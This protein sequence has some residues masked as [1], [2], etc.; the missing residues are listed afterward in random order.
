MTPPGMLHKFQKTLPTV[1]PRAHLK[2]KK[3]NEVGGV[4]GVRDSLVAG[5]VHWKQRRGARAF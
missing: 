1:F 2:K 4:H 3:K 5:F